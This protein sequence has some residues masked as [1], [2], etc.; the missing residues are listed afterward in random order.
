MNTAAPSTARRA[1]SRVPLPKDVLSRSKMA[2]LPTWPT[3]CTSLPTKMPRSRRMMPTIL[4]YG[5]WLENDGR[6]TASTHLQRG[7]D[8]RKGSWLRVPR[9]PS[10]DVSTVVGTA[11]YNG[12]ATGV[13]VKNVYNPD[14]TIE[15]ATAGFFTAKVEPDG[16]FRRPSIAEDLEDTV[17][18]TIDKFVLEH[19]EDNMWSVALEGEHHRNRLARSWRARPMAV[20]LQAPSSATFHGLTPVTW[21]DDAF[22][23]ARAPWLANSTPTSA[24][25]LRPAASGRRK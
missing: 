21:H 5:F 24:T 6:R 2:R 20:E 23:V 7:R 18:G 9:P 11:E 8:L 14:R 17:T 10:G 3:A 25:A 22:T 12:G 1:R 13:Y 4:N 15:S 19:G 16:V